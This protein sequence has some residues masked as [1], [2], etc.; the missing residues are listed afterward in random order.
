MKGEEKK[1]CSTKEVL[2]SQGRTIFHNNK[3]AN[4]LFISIVGSVAINH[5]RNT[6]D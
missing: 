5:L 3:K 2:T 6:Y 4:L 1:E